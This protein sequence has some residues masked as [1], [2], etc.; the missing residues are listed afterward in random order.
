MKYYLAIKSNEVLIHSA[1]CMNL[2]IIMLNER[3]Q[4]KKIICSMVSIHEMSRI[5]KSTEIESSY[6]LSRAGS[7][8]GG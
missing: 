2:E 1:T 7:G 4:A 5:G 6:W 3:T 8:V